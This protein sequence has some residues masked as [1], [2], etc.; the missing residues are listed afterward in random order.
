[1]MWD[2]YS[3]ATG[4]IISVGQEL[5]EDSMNM[6]WNSVHDLAKLHATKVEMHWQVVRDRYGRDYAGP[7]ISLDVRES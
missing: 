6:A 2:I 7:L 1:M 4:V 5:P 3:S